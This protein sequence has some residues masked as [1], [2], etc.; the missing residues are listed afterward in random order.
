LNLKIFLFFCLLY[1]IYNSAL[2]DILQTNP[3]HRTYTYDVTLVTASGTQGTFAKTSLQHYSSTGTGQVLVYM[4]IVVG[5]Y[6]ALANE[7]IIPQIPPDL[8]TG[9]AERTA[10]RILAARV[11]ST[12]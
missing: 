10:A 1:C 7:C 11:S 5:D 6:I 4:P 12:N 8:H 2:V 9:L 3:G